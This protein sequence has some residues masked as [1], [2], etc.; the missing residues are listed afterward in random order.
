IPINCFR[1][2]GGYSVPFRYFRAGVV[3]T[4]P[5]CQGS[6]VPTLSMV[7]AV[8]EALA[9]FHGSWTKAFEDFRT[10]RQRDLDQFEER[11]RGV[12][13]RFEEELRQLAKSEKA[14]GAAAK[15]KGF[16]SF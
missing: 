12:L 15:R 8:E 5:L 9:H 1:C 14:P 11:Q 4:C 6:F 3:F 13:E 10:R 16:F 7:R 2:D